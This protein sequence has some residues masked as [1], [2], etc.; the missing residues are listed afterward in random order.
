[1]SATINQK[2]IQEKVFSEEDNT[3]SLRHVKFEVPVGRT[4]RWQSLIG[5]EK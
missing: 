4:F 2:R 5:I 1:M 3:L